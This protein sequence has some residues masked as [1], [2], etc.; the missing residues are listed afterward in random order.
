MY[1]LT[2]LGKYIVYLQLYD[3]VYTSILDTDKL[4]KIVFSFVQIV[5][6]SLSSCSVIKGY[7]VSVLSEE[8]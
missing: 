3:T 1:F 4:R 5:E 7:H 6:L 2:K 8:F